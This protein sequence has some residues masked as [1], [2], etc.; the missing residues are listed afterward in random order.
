MSVPVVPIINYEN[1]CKNTIGCST[2]NSTTC[3]VLAPK[4]EGGL[5]SAY[6][7]TCMKD[8]NTIGACMFSS[9]GDAGWLPQFPD[10]TTI[11]PCIPP[12]CYPHGPSH[13]VNTVGH[14]VSAGDPCTIV[15]PFPN[16]T[17]DADP[18]DPDS[19][20]TTADSFV[21]D[22]TNQTTVSGTWKQTENSD[23]F[24][25]YPDSESLTTGSIYTPKYGDRTNK[26]Y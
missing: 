1:A 22:E 23:Y 18:Y 20:K 4:D 26:G 10:N 19:C 25:C 3:L 11:G 13:C 15:T 12:N 16:P 17:P 5:Q 7:W 2:V 14:P 21:F 8:D 9:Y 6:G 24:G